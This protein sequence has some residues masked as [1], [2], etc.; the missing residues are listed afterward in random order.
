MHQ[1]LITLSILCP[2]RT[3]RNKQQNIIIGVGK[4]SAVQGHGRVSHGKSCC[5]V[6]VT[7][8]ETCNFVLKYR[9]HLHHQNDLV[10]PQTLYCRITL[11]LVGVLPQTSCCFC[12][13]FGFNPLIFTSFVPPGLNIV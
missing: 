13:L 5:P 10:L 3:V 2:H 12:M 4:L 1:K 6:K 7:A 8:A 11:S 9:M